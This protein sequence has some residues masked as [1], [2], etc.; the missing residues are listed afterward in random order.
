MVRLRPC[1]LHR[2]VLVANRRGDMTS[3]QYSRWFSPTLSY[4]DFLEKSASIK[5]QH[6]QEIAEELTANSRLTHLNMS[7]VEI[8]DPGLAYINTALKS[9]TCL[10]TLEL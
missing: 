6:I 2:S 5:E 7:E 4:C 1:S 10:E 9:N 8:D 3:T